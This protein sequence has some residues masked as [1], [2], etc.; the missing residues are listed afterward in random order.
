M[1][2][3]YLG[4]D[5]GGTAVKAGVIDAAG[6][7]VSQRSLPTQAE[8]ADPGIVVANMVRAGRAALEAAGVQEAASVGVA[9]AGILT[10]ERGVVVRSANFPGW[11]NVPLR[12]QVAQAFGIPAILENDANA[13][14]FGEFSAGERNIRSL[15]MLTLGT[16][17]GSGIINDGNIVHGSTDFA[18]E[19]GHTIIVPDGN[20]CPCGQRGCLETYGSATATARRATAELQRSDR[21]ST[22]RAVLAQAG[23]VTCADV[24]A[25]ALAGDALAAAVWDESCQYIALA[26]LNIVRFLDPQ[27]IVLAGGMSAAGAPLRDAVIRHL[28]ARFWNL[29][30]PTVQIVLATLGN[31]AGVVGAAALAAQALRRGDIPPIGT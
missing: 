15:V 1:P 7:L 22:L 28:C 20:L 3:F 13:A 21:P 27:V 24:A 10:I 25:Q 6:R 2:E 17:V 5:L 19:I 18:G 12:Q 8:L 30:R 26:C 31:N 14:A 9:A 29:S 4:L 16:G 11:A 23:E